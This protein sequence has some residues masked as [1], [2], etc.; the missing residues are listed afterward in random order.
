VTAPDQ[1]AAVAL[2]I[3]RLEQFVSLEAIVIVG[4][5]VVHGGSRFYRPE[6]ITPEVLDELRR[7]VPYDLDHL[8]GEIEAIEAFRRLDVRRPQVACFDTAFHH[9]LPRVAQIIAIPRR[10]EAAGVRRYGFHGLSYSYLM[11]ELARVAGAEAARRRVILAHL[12]PGASLAAVRDGRCVETSMRF[13]PTSDLVMGTQRGGLD[14]GLVR[15]LMRARGL[16]VD[17]FHDPVNHE[18]GLLGVSET[19]GDLRDLLAGQLDDVRAA[20]AV[21]LFC[22]R[23]KTWLGSLVAALGG[24]NTLVFAGGIGENSTEARRRICEGLEFLGISLD[25]ER[26]GLSAPI[27][28]TEYSRA[29]VRVIPTDEESLIARA[30]AGFIPQLQSTQAPDLCDDPQINLRAGR[31]TPSRRCATS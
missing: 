26:N 19:S 22:Y 23:A 29:T 7:I 3:E 20:E 24:V 15:Y 17:Q 9:E 18:S 31:P 27:I 14:P 1:A 21:A 6:L 10:Y 4:H 13:T 8:L 16:T 2:L 28:S 12:G 11:E 25:E 30:A 5:R